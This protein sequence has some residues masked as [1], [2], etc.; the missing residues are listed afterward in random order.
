M[1]KYTTYVKSVFSTTNQTRLICADTVVSAVYLARC[2]NEIEQRF[3]TI[4]KLFIKHINTCCN[5]TESEFLMKKDNYERL[6]KKLNK[7]T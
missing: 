7:H 1:N 2:L 6:E 5:L 3:D 4:S